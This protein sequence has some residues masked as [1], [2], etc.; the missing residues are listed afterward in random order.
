MA[1]ITY[2]PLEKAG[3]ASKIV[4]FLAKTVE[5]IQF[6]RTTHELLLVNDHTLEGI[7]ISR[8]DLARAKSILDPRVRAGG[9]Y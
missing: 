8:G 7:G 4:R 6:E 9:F 5:R 3:I 2:I 1:D